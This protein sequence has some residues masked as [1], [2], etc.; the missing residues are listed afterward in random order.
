MKRLLILILILFSCGCAPTDDASRAGDEIRFAM[1]RQ[2]AAWNDGDLEGFME[3]YWNSP[4]LVF[5]SGAERSLGW[6]TL[7]DKYDAKYFPE[8]HGTLT[9]SGIEIHALSDS[10]AYATG[11]WKL[12]GIE[13]A[14]EGLFTLILRRFDDGW[15]IVHDH[16]S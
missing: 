7:Y 15:R 11:T 2:I 4:E 3:L 1:D 8:G 14:G 12:E 16:T 6:R 5:Q 10:A 13:N 9:F